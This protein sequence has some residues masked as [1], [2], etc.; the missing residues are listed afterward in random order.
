MRNIYLPI[1]ACALLVACQSSPTSDNNATV[2]VGVV[3]TLTAQT[4]VPTPDIQAAINQTLTAMATGSTSLPTPPTDS[5]TPSVEPTLIPASAPTSSNSTP[6]IIF[7]SV[8]PIGS[9]EDL[10][11]RVEGVNPEMYGI[12]VY[13][14]V[15]GG[16]WTKPTFATSVTPIASDGTWNCS[17]ATGGD[18][19]SAT[20]IRAYLIPLGYSPPAMSGGSSLPSALERNAVAKVE[21]TR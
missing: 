11:G 17:Y 12:A 16:W 3:Q 8:P 2:V 20:V 21:A 5:A 1:F 7:T 18:D 14:R 15:G 6:Q 10:S 4:A 19:T 9:S 13:I